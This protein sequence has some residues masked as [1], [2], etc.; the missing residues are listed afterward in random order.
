MP[1]LAQDTLHHYAEL[2]IRSGGRRFRHRRQCDH[3]QHLDNP[4]GRQRV[5]VGVQLKHN[6]L[7]DAKLVSCHIYP[8]S[9][10]CAAGA[11]GG[12]SGRTTVKTVPAPGIPEDFALT[13]PP[14]ALTISFTIKRPNPVPR[15]VHTL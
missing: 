12:V 13:E 14:C 15:M 9:T 8:C 6:Q 4:V 7:R 5:F 1:D 11:A 3:A 2:L 10:S